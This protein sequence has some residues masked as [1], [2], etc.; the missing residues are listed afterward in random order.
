MN[1]IE[2]KL[3]YRRL[4]G[5]MKC[6][7]LKVSET[8]DFSREK[9]RKVM[10]HNVFFE[11][12]N[13]CIRLTALVLV[14]LPVRKLLKRVSAR[15]CYYFWSVIPI[16][17]LIRMSGFLIRGCNVGMMGMQGQS[18]ILVLPDVLLFFAEVVWM[19]G[20]A[21]KLYCAVKPYIR[22]K[23]CLVG[24]ICVRENVYV[25]S[26]VTAPFSMGLFAPKIYLPAGLSKAYY[27]PVIMHEKMHIT[28]RDLWVKAGAT[29]F[30][31]LFWF[32]PVWEKVC[33]ICTEDMEAACD[34]TVIRKGSDAFKRQYA[35]A[36]I[37]VSSPADDSQK[38]SLGC[39]REAIEERINHILHYGKVSKRSKRG[40]LVAFL[41]FGV[42]FATMI[43]QLPNVI[44][45]AAMVE[46]WTGQTEDWKFDVRTVVH[47]KE[48]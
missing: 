31:I 29:F 25:S 28:R 21:V 10:L 17:I 32:C 18:G 36:L 37:M 47:M 2:Y 16:S 3:R 20:M 30:T 1:A 48:R 7:K 44:G 14:M 23:R 33:D 22:L 39:G 5:L 45:R 19:I 6:V 38:F 8:D 24:S 35:E 34:E 40:A 41:S 46:N 42:L 9:L 11:V 13:G 12:V 43:P 26:R 4:T 27:S 15:I